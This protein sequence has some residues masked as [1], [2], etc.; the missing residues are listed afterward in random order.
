MH[1][2]LLL[3]C[4][5]LRYNAIYYP[6]VAALAFLLSPRR[7]GWKIGGLSFSILL[8]AVSFVYTSEK[9]KDLS[10][11]KQFSAFGG[12][13]L[14]NNALYMYEHI[15]AS[16]RGPIPARFAKL[17]TMVR[18]HMD[19]AQ[20]VKMT[21]EDT[22]NSYFYL[23]STRGPLIQYLA[24]DYEKD[25]VTPY[26]KRWAS[27][28][29]LYLDYAWFL[30]KKYPVQFAQ[31]FIAPNA[32]KFAVPPTEFLGT[33]NMGGDSVRQIAKSWFQYQ[34]LKVKDHNS[35]QNPIWLTE[36]YPIFSALVNLLLLIHLI[37]LFVFE[38]WREDR[39]V[40]HLI[41]LCMCLWTLNAG[42]SIFASPIVLRYQLFP[43]LLSLCLAFITGE[44]IYKPTQP[45]TQPAI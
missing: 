14:A 6:I 15:P 28:S 32:G 39:K 3:A 23:W 24:R 43:I 2:V 33:Y 25:S 5:V 7:W 18:Q 41:I 19:T 12:W 27:E 20:K 8:L 21:H 44:L 30:I 22:V 37:G 34:S 29:P 45:K 11:K 35:R 26:F 16:Q 10:G 9:M 36:W 31:H 42:F 17:E 13:Q 40:R 1:G 38:K 4:F